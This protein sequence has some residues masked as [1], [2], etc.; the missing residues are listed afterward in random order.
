MTIK[1]KIF[2]T[3]IDQDTKI[4]RE[5]VKGLETD[6]NDFLSEIRDDDVKKIYVAIGPTRRMGLV[7]YKERQLGEALSNKAGSG[8]VTISDRGSSGP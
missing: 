8:G 7:E 3:T 1:V 5:L 2:S 4:D 6:M